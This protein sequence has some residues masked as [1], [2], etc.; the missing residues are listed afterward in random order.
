MVE[1]GNQAQSSNQAIADEMT[2]YIQACLANRYFMG[3][4][5]VARAGEVLT[6]EDLYK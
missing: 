5:L 6:I 3:S 1:Q 4:V 2:A